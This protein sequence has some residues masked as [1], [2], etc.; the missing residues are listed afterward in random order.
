VNYRE[1]SIRELFWMAR[2]KKRHLGE[3][4]E[5]ESPEMARIV[6]WQQQRKWNVIHSRR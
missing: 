4:V 1:F 6:A 3:L 5:P 2:G